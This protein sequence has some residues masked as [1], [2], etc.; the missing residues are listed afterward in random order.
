[1]RIHC[2]FCL[3]KICHLIVILHNRTTE[4]IKKKPADVLDKP[5]STLISGGGCDLVCREN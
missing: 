3:K 2:G 4:I 5:I 1:M